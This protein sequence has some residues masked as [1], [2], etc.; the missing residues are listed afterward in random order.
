MLIGNE[1]G[2]RKPLQMTEGTD[3]QLKEI[4]TTTLD[5]DRKSNSIDK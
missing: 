2:T 3:G 4:R 1:Q 5:S